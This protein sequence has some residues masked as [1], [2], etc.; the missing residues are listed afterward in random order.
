MREEAKELPELSGIG[1][2]I[3][4]SLLRGS[5]DA[6]PHPHTHALWTPLTLGPCS[7]HLLP[8]PQWS[9]LMDNEATC[10]PTFLQGWNGLSSHPI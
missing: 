7:S 9:L 10:S 4:L 3:F 5:A 2:A 1:S 8:F 6:P